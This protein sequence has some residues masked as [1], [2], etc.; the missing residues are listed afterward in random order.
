MS[1][2]ASGRGF[3]VYTDLH[4]CLFLQAASDVRRILYVLELKTFHWQLEII[5]MYRPGFLLI[6]LSTIKSVFMKIRFYKKV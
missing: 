3:T 5:K 6:S 2:C 1:I 4:E